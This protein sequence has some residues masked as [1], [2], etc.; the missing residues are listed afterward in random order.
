MS[1]Q[2]GAYRRAVLQRRPP[3]R[4]AAIVSKDVV[5]E[6]DYVEWQATPGDYEL[7]AAGK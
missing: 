5:W 6:K 1:E 4:P 7:L 3:G 2:S